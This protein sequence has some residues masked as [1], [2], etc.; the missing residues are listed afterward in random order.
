MIIA[1]AGGHARELAGILAERNETSELF[2]FDDVSTDLVPPIWGRFPV[3]QRLDMAKKIIEKDPR[4]IIGV[5]K[6]AVRKALYQKFIDMGGEPYS[7]I[8]P[9]AHVGEF[10]VM[11]GEGQN[12]MNGA[13]L[14]QDIS[15]G[16]GCLIHIH[17]S[18]HHDCRIGDFCELSPGSRLLGKTTIGNLVSIGSNAV[19]LP[20][21]SV[22]DHAI[23]GAGAVVTKNVAAGSTVK[24]VPA[25]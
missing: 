1:G 11:L 4:F 20:G 17:V 21:I 9:H 18:V 19:I 22:G 13:V 5:G 15:I 2:F 25:R 23:V 7:V 16:K 24:G 14:T 10:N 8:S 6:P 3:V 12:I